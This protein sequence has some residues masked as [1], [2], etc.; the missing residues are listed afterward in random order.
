MHIQWYLA[1]TVATS[2]IGLN[3]KIDDSF[4]KLLSPNCNKFYSANNSLTID[5]NLKK[6][7]CNS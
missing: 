3:F 5:S 4:F 2:L 7:D 6:G 1:I